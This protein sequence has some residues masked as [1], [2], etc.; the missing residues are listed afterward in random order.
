[1]GGVLTRMVGRSPT[2]AYSE[3][4][5]VGYNGT[6]DGVYNASANEHGGFVFTVPVGGYWVKTWHTLIDGV[7]SGSKLTPALWN[8]AN[9]TSLVSADT[10]L[11]VGQEIVFGSTVTN[12]SSVEFIANINSDG[13]AY[14]LPAASYGI[15]CHTSAATRI[16]CKS[17]GPST[18]YFNADTYSDGTEASFQST[19]TSA[20]TPN[21]WMPY[22]VGG[23]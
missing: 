21:I 2:S 7:T 17:I 3:V 8:C 6:V 20:K 11:I 23:P 18:T 1:M 9:G 22:S 19:S 13:S 4:G 5:I 14:F 15:G 16:K 12:G 10:L